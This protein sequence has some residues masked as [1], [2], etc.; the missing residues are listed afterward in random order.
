MGLE[1]RCMRGMFKVPHALG[2][3][4]S[5]SAVGIQQALC[6][7]PQGSN[8]DEPSCGE[9]WLSLRICVPFPQELATLNLSF[10]VPNLDPAWGTKHHQLQQL[11]FMLT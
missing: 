7:S 5:S 4:E 9:W 11:K 6:L 2:Q 1:G 10:P 8:R 3:D